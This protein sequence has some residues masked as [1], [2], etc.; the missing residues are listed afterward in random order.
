M[1]DRPH[2][3][4]DRPRNTANRLRNTESPARGKGDR[5]QLSHSFWALNHCSGSRR[6]Y[7][8]VVDPCVRA[9]V[10]AETSLFPRSTLRLG[11]VTWVRGCGMW[12]FWR[13]RR[14]GCR[15][16]G[17]GGGGEGRYTVFRSGQ[18][19][20]VQEILWS[21]CVG[22]CCHWPGRVW[23]YWGAEKFWIRQAGRQQAGRSTLMLV[24]TM[25]VSAGKGAD[26]WDGVPSEI[27]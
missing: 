21:T 4:V 24:Q 2:N 8:I 12:V 20:S 19:R 15:P 18:E 9:C 13:V 16:D 5:F 27:Q 22:V 7:G 10:R 1:V 26:A 6:R 23:G 17:S 11:C 25:G 3:T 14:S